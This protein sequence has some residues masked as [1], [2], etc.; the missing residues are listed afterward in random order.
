MKEITHKEVIKI[1]VRS[2]ISEFLNSKEMKGKKGYFAQ[3]GIEFLYKYEKYRT[4]FFVTLINDHYEELR[5]I[6]RRIG[7]KR[8]KENTYV[9]S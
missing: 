9:R 2:E 8:K 1:K 5:K 4:A 6:L 3:K 7:R